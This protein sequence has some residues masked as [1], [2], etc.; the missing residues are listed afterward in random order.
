MSNLR[1]M[2]AFLS[3][4]EFENDFGESPVLLGRLTQDKAFITVASLGLGFAAWAI[5]QAPLA[6]VVGLIAWNDLVSLGEGKTKTKKTP[7]VVDTQAETVYDDEKEVPV[8]HSQKA[9]RQAE[10]KVQDKSPRTTRQEPPEA[11]YPHEKTED[12]QS[13]G[14]TFYGDRQPTGDEDMPR[15]RRSRTTK[16]ESKQQSGFTPQLPQVTNRAK[17]D[18]IDRLKEE[19]PGMLRL[20]KSHPVRLVGKQRT[21]KSTMAKLICLLRMVLID[22]HRVIAS[23]PHYEPAN[24]YPDVFKVVG[25]TPTGQRDYE[26]I[27]REWKGL[28]DRVHACKVN[29]NTTI[30]DEFGLFDQVMPEDE[31]KSVLTSCLRETM[32]FGEYPIFIVHGETAAFL[33]GSKGLVTVFLSGTVRVE[34]IGELV[35]D[36]DGLETIRPTGKFHITWL[37][38]SQ[39]EGQIPSWLTEKYLLDLL[40]NPVKTQETETGEE[41][42][43]QEPLKTIYLYA[44]KQNEW[45]TVREVQRKDFPKL[46]GK[47]AKNIRQYFGLLADAGLGEIEEEGRSDSAVSFL[48]K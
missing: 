16:S 45:I 43:L 13:T 18:L 20:V 3:N 35:E 39:E 2:D 46:R 10:P 44:K 41:C 42:R 37:D 32:K 40:S 26:A 48:A 12:E 33:P 30:W 15:Q 34:T 7:P 21:G 24:P 1:K 4:L 8:R 27:Y 5:A 47:T 29:S 25:L 22:D 9:T 36:E 6:I 11:V 28:A 31:I 17:R 38:N 14:W 23:T 19:C